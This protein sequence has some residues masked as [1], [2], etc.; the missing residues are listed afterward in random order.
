M[1]SLAGSRSALKTLHQ[2]DQ[3]DPDPQNTVAAETADIGGAVCKGATPSVE[4]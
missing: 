2:S 1:H 3:S 4:Q